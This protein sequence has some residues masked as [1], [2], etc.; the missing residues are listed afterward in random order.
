MALEDG[1]AGTTGLPKLTPD[2]LKA[3][4]TAAHEKGLP[5]S[6]HITQGAYIQPMLDAGVDD[7]AH[8]AYDYVSPDVMQQMVDRGVYWIPT[9]TVFKNYGA[10]IGGLQNNLRQFIKLGGK[11]ALG[12]DYGGGPGTFELGIPMVE[13]RE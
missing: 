4:V 6:G 3:I 2:E 9:F 13:V 5:V 11:V 12:N 7:I 8:M 10:P 1:Y